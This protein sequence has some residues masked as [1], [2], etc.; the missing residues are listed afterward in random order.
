MATTPSE[1]MAP[2]PTTRQ[3]RGCLFM[4]RRGLKWFVIVLTVLVLLGVAYQTIATETDKRGY[5]PRGQFYTVN[6]HQMHIV[7]KGSGSPAVI[8]QAGATAES[9]WW[10]R[11][12]D[13]LAQHTQVCAYDR[14]G[15]GWSEPVSGQRDATT[16]ASELHALL[17]EA[18][19]AAPYVM[20]GHSFGAVLTRIYAAQYPQDV[21]GIVLVDSQLIDEPYASQSEFDQWKTANDAIQVPLWVMIR[22]GLAR[23]LFSGQFY[24]A[25]YPPEVAAELAALQPRNQTFDTDYAERV[26]AMWPLTQVSAAARDLGDLPLV[27]IWTPVPGGFQ[28]S[29]VA[30][31]AALSRRGEFDTFS[32]NSVTRIIDGADHLSL[33]GNEQHAQQVT[34][35]V[36]DVIEATE[37]G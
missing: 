16:I 20:V 15:L 11:I 29:S 12:Q 8:L 35:A 18:G 36:L 26:A 23:V 4:V 33:L 13:Q 1:R 19:V 34:D 32:S 21:S 24:S 14:P 22:T 31:Q 27:V 7:C 28:A 2:A 37:T 17:D 5:A 30:Q 25:G 3:R 6:G 9:L 10:L